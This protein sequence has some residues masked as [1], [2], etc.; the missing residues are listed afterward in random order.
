MPDPNPIPSLPIHLGK[1]HDVIPHAYALY[2]T[3]IHCTGCGRESHDSQFFAVA[4]LRSRLTNTICKHI[5]PCDRP[6]F[7]LPVE[8]VSR[9][10]RSTPYCV[11]CPSIDLSHLPPPPRIENVRVAPEPVVHYSRAKGPTTPRRPETP[12]RPKAGAGKP[13]LEDLA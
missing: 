2:Y 9:G 13:T 12:N 8:R 11:H 6:L 5:V 3:T 4:H 7:N 10:R 1:S